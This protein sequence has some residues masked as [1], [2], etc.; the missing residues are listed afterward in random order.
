MT[1]IK[2][3]SF[4]L[5]LMVAT[6]SSIVV[7]DT[8]LIENEAITKINKSVSALTNKL[9]GNLSSFAL[10]NF[11]NTKYFDLEI[12]AQEYLKPTIAVMSVNEIL[13]L[14]PEFFFCGGGGLDVKLSIPF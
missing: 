1:F 9:S 8:K 5:S 3:F 2:K 4:L 6:Y 14:D 13:K 11:T 10:Q 12:N 7:A